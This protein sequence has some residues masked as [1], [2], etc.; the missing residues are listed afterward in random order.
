MTDQNRVTIAKKILWFAF[1]LVLLFITI[2]IAINRTAGTNHRFW[3]WIQWPTYGLFSF[4]TANFL[5]VTFVE[6]KS[7]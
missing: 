3:Q 6:K 1:L 5:N 7:Y 2:W 4:A